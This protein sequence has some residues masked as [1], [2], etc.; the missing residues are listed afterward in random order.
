MSVTLIRYSIIHL[1]YFTQ[2]IFF[3]IMRKQILVFS[4]VMAFISHTFFA[5]G[6]TFMVQE[7]SV[8]VYRITEH[9]APAKE[10]SLRVKSIFP[11]WVM[12]YQNQDKS[13]K[14]R[15]EV[16]LTAFD[17]ANNIAMNFQKSDSKIFTETTSVW[18]SQNLFRK[19]S[20]GNK[21]DLGLNYS[22]KTFVKERTNNAK[23]IVVND[24]NTNL[25]IIH[26]ETDSYKGQ[27]TSLSVLD[28]YTN[29]LIIKIANKYQT[30]ELIKIENVLSPE[31]NLWSKR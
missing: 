25:P 28:D 13:V 4:I 18:L 27:K 24:A 22:K 30:I 7:G 20:T 26:C 6:Q 11:N 8:F 10:I 9:D 14:G 17:F 19:L 21:T 31:N 29:P 3:Y 2:E 23:T 1:A 12:T 5:L 16:D 15:I